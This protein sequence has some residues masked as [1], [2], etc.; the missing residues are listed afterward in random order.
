MQ[1]NIVQIG[2]RQYKIEPGQT[3]EIDRL[4]DDVKK[5]TVDKV[6]LKVD[7]DKVQI[8]TP[9]LKETLEL[10]VLETV[11]KLKI[12]VLKFKSK[13]NYRKVTGSRRQMTKVKLQDNS[14]KAKSEKKETVKKVLT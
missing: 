7:D 3:I 11:K 10:D 1:Y 14:P 8:G 12:R 2:S 5:L 4:P 6:L 13:A 9:Y